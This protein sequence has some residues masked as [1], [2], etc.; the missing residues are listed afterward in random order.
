MNLSLLSRTVESVFVVDPI[1]FRHSLLISPMLICPVKK[2]DVFGIFRFFFSF[3]FYTRILLRSKNSRYMSLKWVLPVAQRS[4]LE[5]GAKDIL[6]NLKK[7]ARK[8]PVRVSCQA[9]SKIFCAVL[10]K[11]GLKSLTRKC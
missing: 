1:P 5:C 10:T 11:I 4:L 6:E 3:C 8:K 2:V 7:S 9:M